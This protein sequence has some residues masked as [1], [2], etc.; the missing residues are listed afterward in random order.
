M[1]ALTQ[2]RVL[3]M[4]NYDAVSGEL[5]W[6]IRPSIRSCARIGDL[7]GCVNSDGYLQV[8]TG[9]KAY[10]A[11]RLIWLYVTGEWP[12]DQVDHRNGDRLDN[13]WENLRV[14]TGAVNS[15]NRKKSRSGR[16]YNLPICVYTN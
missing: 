9:G 12:S 15:Q 2:S 11:H 4:F 16:K 7:A 1:G 3:A 14:V 5:L 6:R 10:I 8:K 13:R